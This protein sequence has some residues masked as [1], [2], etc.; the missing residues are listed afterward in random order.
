MESSNS[1]DIK[2]DKYF[3]QYKGKKPLPAARGGCFSALFV[4]QPI[5]ALNL[6]L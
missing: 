3:S 6:I 5:A 1:L 2:L 4:E